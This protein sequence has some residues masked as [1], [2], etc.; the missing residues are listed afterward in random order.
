MPDKQLP[1]NRPSPS[2][3]GNKVSLVLYESQGYF[4]R[5]SVAGNDQGVEL[6]G[7]LYIFTVR[8]MFFDLVPNCKTKDSVYR[9]IL[10][11]NWQK[12]VNFVMWVQTKLVI[13]ILSNYR[14]LT[15]SDKLEIDSAT[16]WRYQF[17]LLRL[18]DRWQ[19]SDH[20]YITRSYLLVIITNVLY[21]H[22]SNTFVDSSF[23]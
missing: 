7:N 20:S 10:A 2:T 4:S 23:L 12:L 18:S 15:K 5:A 1:D 19:G 14:N 9:K 16:R 6:E 13:S 21:I 17:L 22:V 11:D 3:T 8:S